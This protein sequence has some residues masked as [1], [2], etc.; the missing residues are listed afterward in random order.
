MRRVEMSESEQNSP[1]QT[2]ET[3]NLTFFFFKEKSTKT[4]SLSL[5][6]ITNKYAKIGVNIGFELEGKLF[7]SN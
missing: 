5:V 7:R 4:L 3:P 2:G 6:V 1:I